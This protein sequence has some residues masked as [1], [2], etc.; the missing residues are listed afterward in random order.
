MARVL[1]VDDDRSIVRMLRLILHTSGFEVS[2][3]YD[4]VEA[5]D[6]IERDPPDVVLLDLNM[7]VMD[8]ETFLRVIRN[9]GMQ[10]PVIVTSA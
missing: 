2:I 1:I 8:G 10:I 7:P 5:L 4:G 3:A 6:E 9:R